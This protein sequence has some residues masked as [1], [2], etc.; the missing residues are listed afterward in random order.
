VPFDEDQFTMTPNLE[1]VTT[2]D[3]VTL[4]K[5]PPLAKQ[6]KA[7]AEA[8]AKAERAEAGGEGQPV[9]GRLTVAAAVD[10]THGTRA[11]RQREQSSTQGSNRVTAN[12]QALQHF[13][14][15]WDVLWDNERYKVLPSGSPAGPKAKYPVGRP[16]AA[17]KT[18]DADGRVTWLGGA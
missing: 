5:P 4:D 9:P 16:G 13:K 6:L 2:L 17:T 7:E 18:G 12:E 8:R 15:A 1:N 10:K 14:R 11:E 3:H